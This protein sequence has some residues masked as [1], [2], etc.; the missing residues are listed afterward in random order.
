MSDDEFRPIPADG[1]LMALAE[2]ARTQEGFELGITVNVPGATVT[3]IMIGP[4]PWLRILAVSGEGGTNQFLSSVAGAL[5]SM[6][7]SAGE[8]VTAQCLHLRQAQYVSG[9]TFTPT[10][11]ALLW[12]GRISEVAGFS[13]GSLTAA[14]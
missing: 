4:R 1:L 7:D 13:I 9:G 2:V 10:N 14:D 3:G 6:L 8:D 11:A 5:D 12:R